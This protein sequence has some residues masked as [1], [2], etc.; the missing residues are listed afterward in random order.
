MSG[1]MARALP[2]TVLPG[3]TAMVAARLAERLGLELV[4]G[5]RLRVKDTPTHFIDVYQTMYNWR[6]V[7]TPHSAP[8]VNDRGWC[9][10]G[11]EGF[12]RAYSQALI[13]PGDDG[14]EHVPGLWYKT[15]TGRRPQIQAQYLFD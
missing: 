5:H 12:A 3:Y 7:T 13:W 2:M 4:D 11:R 10:T 14:V 1:E 8:R 6:L 9:Y 15:A